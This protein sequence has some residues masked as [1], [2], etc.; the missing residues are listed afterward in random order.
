M[1][2][3]TPNRHQAAPLPST[4]AKLRALVR[5]GLDPTFTPNRDLFESLP[6]NFGQSVARH[7]LGPFLFH[8]LTPAV[9][10]HLPIDL[11]EHLSRSA[12]TT[13]RRALM[14]VAM[15]IRIGRALTAENIPWL[16]I[17]G[18]VLATSLWGGPEKRHAGDIDIV[19]RPEDAA[20]VDALLRSTGYQRILPEFD[21]TPRQWVQY[22]DIKYEF[23]YQSIERPGLRIE[24]KWRLDGISQLSAILNHPHRVTI[25]GQSIPTLPPADNFRYLCHHGARHG[26]FRV[27]WLLDVARLIQANDLPWQD[28]MPRGAAEPSYR[29][30]AQAV[31]LAKQLF[32]LE[33]PP[34]LIPTSPSNGVTIASLQTQAIRQMACD[35]PELT[36]TGEWLRQLRYRTNLEPGHHGISAA[37]K[38]HVWSPLNWQTLP[39]SDR[40]FFLYPV[41]SP[42]LWFYR[43][44]TRSKP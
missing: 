10:S 28:V 17:K 37:L 40:W 41:L 14:R 11:Q 7:R 32:D 36:G 38:P 3:V 21:L 43:V 27:F 16:T 4:L 23:G 31:G 29:S 12:S 6:K 44:V 35:S 9:R 22:L 34:D 2:P 13:A 42:F 18:P 19:I 26:W 1:A 25:A 30:V 8:H 24:I 20:K 5:A 33:P 15:L 39:L